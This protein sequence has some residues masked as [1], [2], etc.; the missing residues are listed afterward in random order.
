VNVSR[1]EQSSVRREWTIKNGAR[2]YRATCHWC[3]GSLRNEWLVEVY[4]SPPQGTSHW[5]RVNGREVIN[6]VREFENNLA[7]LSA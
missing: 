7:Y 3:I 4:I 1:N 5:R 2:E 6:A